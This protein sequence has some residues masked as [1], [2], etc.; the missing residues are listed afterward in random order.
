MIICRTCQAPIIWAV[1]PSGRRMPL[2][3]E[4]REGGNVTLRADGVA[5]VG[6]EGA[7]RY[8]SHFVTCPQAGQHRRTR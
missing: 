8:V 2:D 6:G 4:P 3:A 1:T 7:V 5:I